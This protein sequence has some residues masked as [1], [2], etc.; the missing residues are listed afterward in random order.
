MLL[1]VI[2]LNI[3]DTIYLK[4][5][6]SSELGKKIVLQSVEQI[7]SNGFEQ[8]TL[9]KL[10]DEINSTEASI[11]RYFTN[12]N[13]ILL[14]LV[15]LYWS[16]MDYKILFKTNNLNPKKKLEL[17]IQ[18]LTEDTINDEKV[19]FIEEYKLRKI[20][21]NESAK[22]YLN[23]DVDTDNKLGAYKAYKQLVANLSSIITEI[24]PNFNYPQ[25]L[26]STLIEG[27]H[28]Q[29]FFALHLPS[30]TNTY[31]DEDSV[32]KFYTQLVFSAIK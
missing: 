25:M 28:S 2:Q 1:P 22:A 5:P 9:K 16:W 3:N 13:K 26:I 15:N 19:M 32:V 29:R 21:V 10:A 14:Y 8:F 18:L 24:N 20:I 6:I 23:I 17:A 11:Y 27:A 12:K 7:Y 30:L 31:P 4:D